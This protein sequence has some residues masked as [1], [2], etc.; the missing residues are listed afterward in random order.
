M[1]FYIIVE[2]D[3]TEM[4]VY[5]AWLSILAP[6][7]T[8]IDNA[9]DVSENNYYIFCGGGI[10]SIYT[11][12]KNA[13]LDI[14]EINGKGG[15]Q[16]DYLLVCLDTEDESR[17]YIL[18]QINKELKSSGVSLQNAE[19]IVF[20]QKVCMET[21]FLGNQN[22]FKDNPQNAEYLEYIRYYN[23]GNHN[24]E[25]MGNIDAD[26]F[27]TTARF[28]L[29]YLKRMLEERNMNYSKSNTNEVQQQAYLRQLIK[30]FETT[31]HIPSFGSWYEFVKAHFK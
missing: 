20:E 24:P 4:S 22:V 10:P 7:Y 18:K 15:A 29:R 19:L 17:D 11:H 23:V 9:R 26:R 31:G 3:K 14:N 1:N 2:G 6:A 5:P 25:D 30:R 28:H 12:I 8:R 13:V 16:Y 27:A 21:W